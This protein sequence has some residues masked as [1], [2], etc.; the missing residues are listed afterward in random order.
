MRAAPVARRWAA[1]SRG[2]GAAGELPSARSANLKGHVGKS[3]LCARA[4]YAARTE[5]A[6]TR[7]DLGRS[8]VPM[9]CT[10]VV[11]QA[12]RQL[13]A[14]GRDLLGLTIIIA[15]SGRLRTLPPA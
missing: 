4:L 9:E 10:L 14:V 11:A 2:C 8:R 6:R 12:W 13:P 3:L 7:P 1:A 5:V 15:R